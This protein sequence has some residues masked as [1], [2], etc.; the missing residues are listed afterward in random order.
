[1]TTRR[2][3]LNTTSGK[4]QHSLYGENVSAE[5]KI[6]SYLTNNSFIEG[7][8]AIE[9]SVYDTDIMTCRDRTNEFIS[10]VNSMNSRQGNG[11]IQKPKSAIEARS[12][13]MVAAK[14]IGSDLGRT[15][16]KLEKLT[17]CKFI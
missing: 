12:E 14:K 8:T 11:Y 16:E 15:F 5:G 3:Y 7:S 9:G 4:Q 2:R 1:M 13:F 10:T 6:S 17:I